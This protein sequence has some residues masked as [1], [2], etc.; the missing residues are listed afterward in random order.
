MSWRLLPL[1]YLA[2][3]ALLTGCAKDTE[4]VPAPVYLLD[5]RWV[6]TELEGQAPPTAGGTTTNL[7]L[8]SVGS[9]MSGRAFC[10]G[11]GGKYLLTAGSAQLTFAAPFS[12]YATC[13]EQ[14]QETRYFQLLPQVTRYVINN[15][16]LALYDAEHPAPLLVFKAAE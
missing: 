7:V 13:P 2:V 8:N 3:P 12:T 11:Y 4:P 5:Q 1:L 15:R 9:T 14:T 16:R 6:L 10:N